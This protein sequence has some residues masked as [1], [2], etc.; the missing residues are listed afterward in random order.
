MG[1]FW[2]RPLQTDQEL[3]EA[4]MVADCLASRKEALLPE[5]EKY[6]EV[7]C[8]LIEKY[9]DEHVIIPDAGSADILRFLI[10]QRGVT[11]QTVA[12]ETGIANSTI[13][14]VLGGDRELTR[15]H[16]ERMAVYFGVE[17]AVFFPG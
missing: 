7:L 8:D 14:A 13:S 9:E 16:I 6:F 4:M 17:P 15:K 11:Q 5:E 1:R 10:E 2:L 12:L 3:T